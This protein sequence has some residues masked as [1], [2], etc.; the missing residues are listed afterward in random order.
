MTTFYDATFKCRYCEREFDS[1]YRYYGSEDAETH[2]PGLMKFHPIH[3]CEEGDIGIGDFIGFER[4]DIG[5]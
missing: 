1:E 4:V 3:Y 2:I 5:D